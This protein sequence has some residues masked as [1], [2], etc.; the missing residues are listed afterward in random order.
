MQGTTQLFQ[1]IQTL[2]HWHSPKVTH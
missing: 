2:S 1:S